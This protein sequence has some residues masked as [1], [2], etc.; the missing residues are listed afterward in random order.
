[1]DETLVIIKFGETK[2][3]MDQRKYRD[4]E[5]ARQLIKCLEGNSDKYL[6]VL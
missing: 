1:M 3:W 6:R 2:H 4:L 5:V